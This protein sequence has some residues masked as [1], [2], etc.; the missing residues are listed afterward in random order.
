MD[1][2]PNVP[3]LLVLSPLPGSAMVELL[4]LLVEPEDELL[5]D[6]PALPPPMPGPQLFP[7]PPPNPE[8]P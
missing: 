7:P 4:E 5:V 8:P 2:F 1:E 6:P 3:V